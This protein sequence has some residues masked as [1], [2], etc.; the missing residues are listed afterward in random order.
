MNGDVVL[1]MTT[2]FMVA[3]NCWKLGKPLPL[4]AEGAVAVA[5]VVLADGILCN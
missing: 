1:P 5:K 3:E 2:G 4:F